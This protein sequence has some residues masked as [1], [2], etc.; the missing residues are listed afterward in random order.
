MISSK[1][2]APRNP[3]ASCGTIGMSPIRFAGGG[4]EERVGR[5]DERGPLRKLE[6][7]LGCAVQGC[8]V[9]V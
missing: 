7:V 9:E 6:F 8:K 2:P 4:G 5:G 1:S 3:S